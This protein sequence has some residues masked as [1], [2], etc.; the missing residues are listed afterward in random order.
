M[1]AAKPTPS[2]MA[3]TD[4]WEVHRALLDAELRNPRLGHNPLWKLHRADAFED[5]RRSLEKV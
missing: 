3:A 4:A 1:S 2:E 5:F